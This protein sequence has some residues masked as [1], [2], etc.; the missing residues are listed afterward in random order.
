MEKSAFDNV[1]DDC[2]SYSL[3]TVKRKIRAGVDIYSDQQMLKMAS[4]LADECLGSFDRCNMVLQAL[5]GDIDQAR[6]LL[7]KLIFASSELDP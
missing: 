2:S 4:M 1:E 5:R 7:S 3:E 6:K